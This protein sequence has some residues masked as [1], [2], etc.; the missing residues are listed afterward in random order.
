MEQPDLCVRQAEPG[1]FPTCSFDVISVFLKIPSLPE[2]WPAAKTVAQL[3]GG[4]L[5]MRIPT[6]KLWLLPLPGGDLT[7]FSRSLRK[8]SDAAFGEKA[9]IAVQ[10]SVSTFFIRKFTRTGVRL[11]SLPYVYVSLSG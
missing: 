11:E 2:G 6:R 3:R 7:C 5:L 1:E 10:N 4:S 8:C 9:L